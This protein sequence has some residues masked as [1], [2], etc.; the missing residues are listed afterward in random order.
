MK[1]K[2]VCKNE[3]A[4]GCFSFDMMYLN[5]SI[6]YPNKYYTFVRFNFRNSL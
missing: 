6:L 1:R 2:E 5:I 4:D 3:A